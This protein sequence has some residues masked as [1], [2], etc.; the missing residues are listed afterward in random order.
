M[1]GL[2]A[3]RSLALFSKLKGLKQQFPFGFPRQI[4]AAVATSLIDVVTYLVTEVKQQVFK[5]PSMPKIK[6]R[7]PESAPFLLV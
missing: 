7:S 5:S 1:E 6:L 4:P 3:R 2:V